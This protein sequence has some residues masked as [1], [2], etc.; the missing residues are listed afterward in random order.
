MP[1]ELPPIVGPKRAMVIMAHPDD[2][3]FLCGGTIARW[4]A[5]GWDVSYVIVTSGD[6][7]T[8]DPALTREKLAAMREDE[9][10]RAAEVLG[11]RRCIFL[12]Y[13]DGFTLDDAEFRGQLVELLRKHR[14]EV[15]V[16]W[17]GFRKGFNHR[18]HRTV[19]IAAADAVF[20]LSRDHLYYPEQQQA[21]LEPVFVEDVLLAGSDDDNYAV[22]ISRFVEKKIEA[23]LCHESQTGGRTR[24]DFLKW[25]EERN[26]QEPDE[27]LQERFKRWS[28]RRPLRQETVEKA[29]E[30]LS[31]A[32]APLAE[33]EKD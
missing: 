3:D 31:A 33:S 23:I 13:P 10:R 5:E 14:P 2:V 28:L 21:G 20:P 11:V 1:D 8:H 25:L 26:R 12:G 29:D 17:D 7:G 27:P 30:A 15:V 19:G 4:C 9:Q 24:E 16:T 6:K 18:D 32:Q 22:D